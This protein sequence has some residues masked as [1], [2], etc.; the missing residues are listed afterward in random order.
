MY[1]RLIVAALMLAMAACDDSSTG[2]GES[3]SN[4]TSKNGK[5]PTQSMEFSCDVQDT[6]NGVRQVLNFPNRMYEITEISRQGTDKILL[7]YDIWFYGPEAYDFPKMCAKTAEDARFYV[8]GSYS[9]ENFHLVYQVLDEYREG[10]RDYGAANSIEEF[11]LEALGDCESK[12]E[13][14]LDDLRGDDEDY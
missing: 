5:R 2:A 1:K 9:C 4:G 6:E 13:W 8:E 3:T 10:E 14:Y 11:R 7:D 12:Y